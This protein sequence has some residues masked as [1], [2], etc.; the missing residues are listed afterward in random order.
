MSSFGP[1]GPTGPEGTT[2][3][4]GPTGL[5]NT[6]P[7]GVTGPTGSTGPTGGY[8]QRGGSSLGLIYSVAPTIS[9]TNYNYV[10]FNTS[11]TTD[12]T[13]VVNDLDTSVFQAVP[14]HPD[15]GSGIIFKPPSS[16]QDSWILGIISVS[17]NL[18]LSSGSPIFPP[19]VVNLVSAYS[20]VSS[21]P[22]SAISIV[23]DATVLFNNT[24]TGYQDAT[25]TFT[26]SIP[27][28]SP[29]LI[30]IPLLNFPP[31]AMTKTLR[32]WGLSMS[33]SLL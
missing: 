22:F 32:T 5:S 18:T 30:F 23:Q 31:V 19:I 17:F 21:T 25:M 24:A 14:S 26:L 4:T 12:R 20:S 7:T 28:G 15:Y 10:S 29:N 33:L 13:V 2:G 27:S 16:G 8:P 9:F 3:P 6:G 11:S 1:T